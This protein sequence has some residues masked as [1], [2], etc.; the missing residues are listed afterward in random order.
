MYVQL[1]IRAEEKG[2]FMQMKMRIKSMESNGLFW[3]VY[4]VQYYVQYT[5][6]VVRTASQQCECLAS[7]QWSVQHLRNNNKIKQSSAFHLLFMRNCMER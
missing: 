5:Y 4:W 7:L 1:N 2:L 6:F 3:I